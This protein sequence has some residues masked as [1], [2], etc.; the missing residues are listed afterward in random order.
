MGGAWAGYFTALA[1]I[2]AT[3][4]ALLFVS[5]QLRHE[6]WVR[7]ELR[8]HLAI[9]TLLE[10]LTPAIVS[11]SVLAPLFDWRAKVASAAPVLNSLPGGIVDLLQHVALW[12]LVGCL[13]GAI[14]IVNGSWFVILGLRRLLKQPDKVAGAIRW[15][16]LLSPLVYVEYGLLIYSA[17]AGFLTLAAIVL[18]W[19][20]FSGSFETWWFFSEGA[21]NN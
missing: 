4:V 13:L 20:V 9:S 2:A 3:L 5:I 16:L 8:K 14:G 10:F 6:L 21:G 12:H 1:E 11:V 7:D 17:I 15:P 18:L 19:L